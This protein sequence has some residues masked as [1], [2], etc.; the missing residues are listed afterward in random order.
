MED[1]KAQKKEAEDKEK[2]LWRG[3]EH[4]LRSE[5]F[6]FMG[7]DEGDGF[8]RQGLRFL[9]ENPRMLML[10]FSVIVLIVCHNRLVGSLL[11]R[12]V[13][14]EAEKEA[15]RLVELSKESLKEAGGMGGGGGGVGGDGIDIDLDE[16]GNRLGDHSE[17]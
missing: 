4:L 17:L 14:S 13:M 3:K 2:E 8:L 11:G 16:G 1:L 9:G 5:G 12:G 10:L 7:E 15:R 6:T